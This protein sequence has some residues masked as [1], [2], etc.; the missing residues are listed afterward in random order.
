MCLLWNRH[1]QQCEAAA[2]DARTAIDLNGWLA[3][4]AWCHI[5]MLADHERLHISRSILQVESGLFLMQL[6]GLGFPLGF[7]ENLLHFLGHNRWERNALMFEQGIKLAIQSPQIHSLPTDEGGAA[8]KDR[9]DQGD[10]EKIEEPKT[11]K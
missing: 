2:E 7:A 6:D 1:H 9:N 5:S 10:N 4:A 3:S 11:G 8:S